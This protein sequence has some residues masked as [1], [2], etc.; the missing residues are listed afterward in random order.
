MEANTPPIPRR[1]TKEDAI[2]PA[3]MLVEKSLEVGGKPVRV[4]DMAEACFVSVSHFR[5]MFTA[6]MK[7]SPVEY[8]LRRKMEKAAELL[9]E[10]DMPISEISWFCGCRNHSTFFREFVGFY[11]CNPTE[12]REKQELAQND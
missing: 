4:T 10:S 12:Y 2:K 11:G 1:R 6:R 7:E 3:L 8:L 5:R 9:V